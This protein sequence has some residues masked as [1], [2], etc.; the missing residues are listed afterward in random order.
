MTQILASQ[1]SIAH[2][3]DFLSTQT[4]IYHKSHKPHQEVLRRAHK[5]LVMSVL[6][7]AP[8]PSKGWRGKA[9]LL[10]PKN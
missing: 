6:W 7:M 3:E 8:A 1:S 4:W 10:V 5:G 2:K 9:F